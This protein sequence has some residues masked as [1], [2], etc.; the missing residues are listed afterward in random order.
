MRLHPCILAAACWLFVATA[1]FGAYR[2]PRRSVS[3]VAYAIGKT[4]PK[5]AL[6]QRRQWAKLLIK[7]AT[8]HN[9]DPL[10]GWAIIAHESHWNPRAV[11]ADGKDIGLAQIRY[12]MS[13]ACRD[14]RDSDAC[15]RSKQ[16]LFSPAVNMARMAGA[17]T[18]WRKLCKKKIGKGPLM[19]QWLQGYGGYSRPPKRLCGHKRVRVKRKG[20][21]RWVW[22]PTKVPAPVA[23]ILRMRKR[24]I[25]QLKQ[26][27]KRQRK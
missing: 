20:R 6:E 21:W 3:D 17:I 8:K 27:R 23:R 13:R 18:A 12:T 15:E 16:A 4:R 5:L 7:Q 24:M 26:R 9:F 11:S 19:S 1:A 14:D 25:K 2:A 10:S 22:R